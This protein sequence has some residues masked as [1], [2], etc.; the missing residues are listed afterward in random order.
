MYNSEFLMAHD[1]ELEELVPKLREL[2]E[3]F[4]K[5]EFWLKWTCPKCGERC[6]TDESNVI[7]MEG[8]V[9]T[10]R[11]DGTDCGEWYKGTKYGV[12]VALSS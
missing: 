9:H 11:A 6:A 1:W 10:L 7:Y 12:L 8:N 2:L 4:P 3:K 5:T